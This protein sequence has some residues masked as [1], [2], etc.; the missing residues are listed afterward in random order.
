MRGSFRVG[1]KSLKSTVGF[2]LF[3]TYY[4][5]SGLIAVKVPTLV[6]HFDREVHVS[7][8]ANNCVIPVDNLGFNTFL[9]QIISTVLMDS[10]PA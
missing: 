6:F 10:S 9:L 3:D 8:P 2:F 5:L 7:L 4:D 1:I